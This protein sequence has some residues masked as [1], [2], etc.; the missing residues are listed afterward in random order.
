MTG[1]H[2]RNERPRDRRSYEQHDPAAFVGTE[3]LS[4]GTAAFL[5]AAASLGACPPQHSCDVAFKEGVLVL[6]FMSAVLVA[7]AALGWTGRSSRE[8]NRSARRP[9]ESGI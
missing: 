8:A 1:R 9:T 5:G 3:V 2:V 6:S 4:D 7:I